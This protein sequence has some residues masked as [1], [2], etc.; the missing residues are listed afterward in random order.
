M[1]NILLL[2]IITAFIVTACV[3]TKKFEEQ[4][5]LSE[6]YLAEKEDCNEQL[7]STQT[8]LE[9]KSASLNTLQEEKKALDNEFSTLQEKYSK[10]SESFN[11]QKALKEKANKNYENYMLSSS[12]RQE[13]LIQDL[14]EKERVL[15]KKEVDLL[16]LQTNISDRENQLKKIKEDIFNKEKDL[17]IKAVKIEEL[18]T[19]LIS[20]NMIIQNLKNNIVKALKEFTSDELT[21]EEKEGKIYVSLSEKLLFKPGSFTLDK[22]GE[23][24]IEKLAEV[25]QKQKD[26]DIIVEGHTDADHFKGKGDMIDNLD[27]SMKRAS[28]VVRVLRKNNVTK[29]KIIASGRGSTKPIADNKTKE[30]KAKNRRTDIILAPN[31]EK[32]IELIQSN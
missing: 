24:A 20:Q 16:K 5:A 13:K 18:E 15:N 19:K 9:E 10:Q 3:P 2:S 4:T 31:L 27:L 22:D 30:G 7:L 29:E 25:L 8:E 1:K 17:S 21:V 26:I 14:A 11:E 12:K 23:N 6:K 28:S 32:L